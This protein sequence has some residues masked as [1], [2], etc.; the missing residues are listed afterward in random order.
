MIKSDVWNGSRAKHAQVSLQTEL[1]SA[2]EKCD[3]WTRPNKLW[4]LVVWKTWDQITV[5]KI[6]MV[7]F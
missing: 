4:K 3:V 5:I 2:H 6:F 1:G 7:E